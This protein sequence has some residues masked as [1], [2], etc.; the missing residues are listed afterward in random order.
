MNDAHGM[1]IFGGAAA[2]GKSSLVASMAA[3]Y[4]RENNQPLIYYDIE[5]NGSIFEFKTAK[6]RI[7]GI[8]PAVDRQ[9]DERR[10]WK[11]FFG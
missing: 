7:F 9:E 11:R 10:W 3:R 2:S 4:A 1:N 8:D 5:S 6:L